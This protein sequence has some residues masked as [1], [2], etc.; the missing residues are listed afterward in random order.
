MKQHLC[1]ILFRTLSLYLLFAVVETACAQEQFASRYNITCVT[2]DNGLRHNFID[3]IY[4]DRRGFLWI[5]T[6]GS[7]LSR[8]DGYEFIHYTVG[9]LQT[10]LKSNFIRKV[11]EDDFNRL[12]IVSDG[13][14]DIFD[15]NNRKMVVPKGC[16]EIFSRLAD[17]PAIHVIRDSQGNIWIAG[18]DSIHRIRFNSEGTISTVSS[19]LRMPAVQTIAMQDI[20]EDGNIWVGIENRICKLSP[21]GDSLKAT[22]VASGLEFPPY[23]SV[24]VFILKEN[25]IWIGT[26]GGLIRYN[27]NENAS[28]LYEYERNNLRSLTQNYITDL[29]VTAEKQ[30]LISTLKG[31]NVYNPISDDFDHLTQ[32]VESGRKALNSDFINCLYIDNDL[33]WIGTE[34]GGINKLT[35]RKLSVKSYQYNHE[36]PRSISRNL[37]NAIYEDQKGN[38]WIGTVEGGLNLKRSGSDTFSRYTDE[39]SVPLSHNSISAITADDHNRLWA[40][41][42]GNG[43]NLIDLASPG[44]PVKGY[45]S[46]QNNPGISIDFIGSLC[47][48]SYNKGVWIGSNSGIFFYDSKSE[49]LS[50]PLPPRVNENIRG[51]IG[52]IIDPEKRLWMGCMEGVYIIDLTSRNGDNLFLHTHLKYKLDEPESRLT[53]KV[54]SFCLT[55]DSVLWIGSNGCGIYRHIPAADGDL[56]TFKGYTTDHG[57]INNNVLGIL[58]DEKGKLWISTNNG[59]SCFDPET[60]R[61]SN[62]TR[63]DGLPGNQFYWNA[64]YK[65]GDGLLWF[66]GVDGLVAIDPKRADVASNPAHTSFT[67]LTIMNE[68]VLPGDKYIDRDISVAGKVRLHERDK[69]FALE[70]SALNFESPATATYS[71]RLLGFDDQWIEVPAS[72]RY[73]SYTNIPSGKYTFQV[74]YSPDELFDK[75]TVTELQVIVEPFFYKTFWFVSLMILLAGCLVAYFYLH[76]IYTLQ[77]Q[78]KEL[79]RKVE[80]RT[81]EL[82]EQKR[83]L[84]EKTEELSIQNEVLIQQNEKI[85]RQKTQL[86]RMSKKVQE[87]TLDKISFFT[88]ITHEFRT[89]ITLIIGPIERALKLSYNPQVIEQLHFV[90]R[91]SK[92]LLSL[93]NQLMDFRKVE[94]GKMEILKT[95]GDFLEFIHAIVAPF[96]VFAGERGITIRKFFRLNDPHLLFDQDAMQKIISNLLSNGIK[97][98]PNGGVVTIYAASIT[99]PESGGEKLYLA[100]SDTGN[101]IPEEDMQKIFNRF[102]QSRSEVKY[103]VY[104]QSGTGIGLYLCRQIVRQLGGTILAS[105][106]KKRGGKF[107]VILP[108]QREDK[109]NRLLYS[110]TTPPVASEEKAETPSDFIPGRKTILIVEDNSDMRGFIRSIL[111]AEYNILEADEGEKAL[112]VLGESNVDF[113]ISDLMMPVMDGIELSRR[114]KENFAISHIPFLMLT[115]KTSPQARTESY[116][117]GVDAYLMKPFDEEVLLARIRNIFENRKRIQSRFTTTMDVETLQME[118]ESNDKKF[119]NRALEVIGDNYR[120]SYYESADFIEAMGVSKSLLN[121]KLQNLTGQSIGQ[122]IRNYR[123]NIARELL[124]KNRRT[125]NMNIS[126]IA[127]E[128]GFNDPKY[129]TR[130]FTKRFHIA[131]SDILTVK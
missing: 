68:E 119:L 120:N 111:S 71:Y 45:L 38:L 67:R 112:T 36:E 80:E 27:R 51:S 59:L 17:E 118:E 50:S 23:I 121:K 33:I 83:L 47:Y 25:E 9:T 31:V 89:P 108:L 6:G 42:W 72:R 84:E 39:S 94:A 115:A 55:R 41:T 107:R 95:R 19:L 54:S 91:N 14:V 126:E 93:V 97:F 8:Y 127:Y 34:T 130:C 4:K 70:F 2:M 106:N 73:A 122:F 128:V 64:Y 86:I 77:Q 92:Y 1:R 28:K 49:R 100:I 24:N 105:N 85:T 63:E 52:A 46:S 62:Y 99:D 74:R 69:S 66:G 20:D 101:G 10:K 3:D 110:P 37:I 131:P 29:A 88:S 87:L 13:G 58:E 48:D 103:P 26:N 43:V 114:V 76:R 35:P 21:E 125:R 44:F 116:R 57:L 7:G 61:F 40:G 18:N 129:F 109:E 75:G 11:C 123:L 56:G 96:E 81:S 22:L 32:K 65:S 5:S 12:W 102:Y 15:L 113:I 16:E 82:K 117:M 78:K 60:E 30:L 53:E 90:E 98:T 124:E 104:G 79:H